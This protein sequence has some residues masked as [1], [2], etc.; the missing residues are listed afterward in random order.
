MEYM[1][2]RSSSVVK[3][4]TL[5]LSSINDYRLLVHLWGENKYTT[6]LLLSS[7]THQKC[8]RHDGMVSMVVVMYRTN[9]V[10]RK[11]SGQIPRQAFGSQ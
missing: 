2:R 9:G 11:E 6:A 4:R 10:W 7:A 3:N 8:K 1:L 5:S